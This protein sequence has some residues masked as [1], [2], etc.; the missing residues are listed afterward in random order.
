MT[1]GSPAR[2]SPSR[3]PGAPVSARAAV[4][5]PAAPRSNTGGQQDD[6]T[7]AETAQLVDDLK[8]QLQKAENASEQ[9]Q[10]QLEVLQLRIDEVTKE[11][12]SLEEKIHA[13]DAQIM[14]LEAGAKDYARQKREMEQSIDSERSQLAKEKE[15]HIVKE[16]ELQTVIQRLNENLKQRDGPRAISR[17]CKFECRRLFLGSAD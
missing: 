13:Q 9:Y 2:A 16:E 15:D 4:R 6:D 7:R 1:T 17:S 5:K 14:S 10:K 11:Y 12:V 8:S 3:Q